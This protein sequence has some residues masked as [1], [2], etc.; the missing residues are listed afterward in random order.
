MAINWPWGQTTLIEGG[1]FR[2]A[3][4]DMTMTSDMAAQAVAYAGADAHGYADTSREQSLPWIK[5]AMD[6]LLALVAIVILA[7]VMLAVAVAM[8]LLDGTPLVFGHSRVGIGGRSFKCLKFRSMVRDADRQLE[9]LLASDPVARHE[10]DTTRKLTNDPRVSPLGNFLRRSSLDELPQLFNVLRGEMSLVGP[11]PITAAE[12]AHYGRHYAHYTAV[13]PG[14]TGAWQVGGRSDT[15]YAERVAMDVDYVENWSFG[16][17]LAILY[18]TVGV[19]LF[20]K[21]AR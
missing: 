14:V 7:P 13:R 5:V 20:G 16:R 15:T 6:K 10:W 17:D 12:A 2:T 19:V 9:V 11:R 4:V 1:P 21:G 18:K 8:F 3:L